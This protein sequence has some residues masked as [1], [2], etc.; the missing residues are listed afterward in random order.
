MT[1]ARHRNPSF[2]LSLWL[3]SP[4]SPTP[5]LDR[6]AVVPA[7]AVIVNPSLVG[8]DVVEDVQGT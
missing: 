6:W 5:S 3:L 7:H 2:G 4:P 1:D 8:N